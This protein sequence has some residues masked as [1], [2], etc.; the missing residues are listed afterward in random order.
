[1]NL[2]PPRRRPL[3]ALSQMLHRQEPENAHAGRRSNTDGMVAGVLA[4]LGGRQCRIEQML[5]SRRWQNRSVLQATSPQHLWT[6]LNTASLCQLCGQL[7]SHPGEANI[8]QQL[9]VCELRYQLRKHNLATDHQ[10]EVFRCSRHSRTGLDVRRCTGTLIACSQCTLLGPP[11]SSY[12]PRTSRT[13]AAHPFQH[14]RSGGQGCMHAVCAKPPRRFP[15][16]SRAYDSKAAVFPRRY[17]TRGSSA[18]LRPP[19][20]SSQL[21]VRVVRKHSR[22]VMS[23]RGERRERVFSSPAPC[24]G[25]G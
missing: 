3:H 19:L 13:P 14:A 16:P 1:M 10:V 11:G 23:T 24:H 21:A 2:S 6:P 18:R 20:R 12:T 9:Q 25:L 8:L 5:G 15:Q 17:I 4:V 22:T 7:S